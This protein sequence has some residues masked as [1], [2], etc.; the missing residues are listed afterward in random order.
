MSYANSDGPGQH[1]HWSDMDSL[2]SSTYTVAID[3][4]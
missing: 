4:V 1:A 2:C 3:S